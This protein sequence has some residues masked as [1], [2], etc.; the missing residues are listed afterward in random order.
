MELP[1]L[2][3]SSLE[4]LDV[5]VFILICIILLSIELILIGIV[6]MMIKMAKLTTTIAIHLRDGSSFT[7]CKEFI[8]LN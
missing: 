8:F 7:T 1:Y 4:G 6:A 3:I 2:A 5:L